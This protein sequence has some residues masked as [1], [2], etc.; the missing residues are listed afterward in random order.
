MDFTPLHYWIL[1]KLLKRKTQIFAKNN[2]TYH[3]GDL[4]I[5]HQLTFD[6]V[7]TATRAMAYE[8]TYTQ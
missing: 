1:L 8:N 6:A 2:F 3:G 7:M 4:N 5:D